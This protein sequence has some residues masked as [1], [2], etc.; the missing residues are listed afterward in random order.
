M[1]VQAADPAPASP[2]ALLAELAALGR[3][4]EALE[5]LCTGQTLA[6][7]RG[8]P[9]G[10]W[11]RLAAASP[12]RLGVSS[13][14]RLRSR[15]VKVLKSLGRKLGQAVGRRSRRG[16][17]LAPKLVPSASQPPSARRPA[18]QPLHNPSADRLL[19]RP[20]FVL[21]PVRSGSTLL[22]LLLDGHSELHA[23][24]E[25]HIRRLEVRWSTKLAGNAMK[26]L[27]LK[28]KDLEHLLWD[29]VMHRELVR[30]GKSYIVE[31]TPANV[32]AWR[33]I[34]SCW[35]DARFI[36][37][38][39][40]PVSIVQSW[41]D[42]DPKRRSLEEA[43]REVLDYV[44]AL[45]EARNSLDGHTVRYEDLTKDPATTLQGICDFLDIGWEPTMLEYGDR[46]AGKL[47]R[48]LGD[49]RGK[50]RSGIIQNGRELPDEMIIPDDLRPICRAWGY[51]AD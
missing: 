48:G 22:R 35:P 46:S 43:T 18:P 39:R 16:G 13:G 37:L 47:R 27:G 15:T 10:H 1:T 50:I 4:R 45:E 6:Y 12:G 49:W 36:F 7:R 11:A 9:V 20:I 26:E 31:K 30:S 24:H 42:A 41:H 51:L 2:S 25:L 17:H 28:R 44:T 32:F 3:A 5:S 34:A 19:V 14:K 33:R 21:A 8:C 40:H 23:P 38:L 29:R